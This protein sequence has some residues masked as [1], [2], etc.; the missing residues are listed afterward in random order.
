MLSSKQ[1]Q[2]LCLAA[3]GL[4]DKEIARD[5]GISHRSVRTYWE[6]IFLTLNAKTRLHAYAI[7]I[8]L[9]RP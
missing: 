1:R 5:M 3:K 7:W 9:D 6:R 4:I 8:Y 2:V